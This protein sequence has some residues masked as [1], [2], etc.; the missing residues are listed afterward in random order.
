MIVFA[1][2][3]GTL[4]TISF[5]PQLLSQFKGRDKLSR[6]FLVIYLIGVINWGLFGIT[7]PQPNIP[8][9]AISAIQVVFVTIILIKLGI[10]ERS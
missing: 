3:A 5:I 10:H 2:A 9:V 8:L 1:I 6:L 7:M 4:C